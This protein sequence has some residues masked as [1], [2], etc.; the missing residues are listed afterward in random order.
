[1]DLWSVSADWRL[2]QVDD[3]AAQLVHSCL[4]AL[5]SLLEALVQGDVLLGN[6]Q[7]CLKYKD[8]FKQ[9]YQQ[10]MHTILKTTFHDY[11]INKSWLQRYHII[12]R[13]EN[14]QI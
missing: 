2:S 9:L 10:C 3:A 1:M 5:R 6:L 8:Q 13:Q 4:T 11:I 14:G 12:Y 7:T